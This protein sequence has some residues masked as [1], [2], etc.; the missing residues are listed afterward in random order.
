MNQTENI[1]SLIDALVELEHEWAE[2]TVTDNEHA[3]SVLHE[4]VK[5]QRN[6]IKSKINRLENA[7]K[8]LFDAVDAYG[9]EHM[10]GAPKQFY[11]KTA[12][13]ALS[14]N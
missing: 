5:Q 12:Q 11:V 3:Q 1:M 7:T 14:I 9:L 2:A 4:K 10:H 13:E 8:T 6:A